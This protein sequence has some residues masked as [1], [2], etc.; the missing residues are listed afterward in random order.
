MKP[1]EAINTLQ[2]KLAPD[3]DE[4]MAWMKAISNGDTRALR[5]L[6]ALQFARRSLDAGK[7]RSARDGALA[8]LS[9]I[10][11]AG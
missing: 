10:G 8:A 6:Q 3:G 4:G 1:E 7:R 11:G 9:W 2:Q 5:G